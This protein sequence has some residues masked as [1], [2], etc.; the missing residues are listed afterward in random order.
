MD[1]ADLAFTP[2]TEM[3]SLIRRKALSPVEL[4]GIILDR[5]ERINPIL[6]AYCTITAEQARADARAAEAALM[7]GD[8]LGALHGLPISIK[9]L[10]YTRGVRTT[11]GS[12][13]FAG[14]VPT[15]DAPVVERVKAAG[16]IVIGKTNTPEFGWKG[17]TSND[18]FGATYNPWDRTRSAGGSSGGAAAALAAGLGPLALGTDGAGSIRIPAAFCGVVGLKAQL[19]RVPIYPPSTLETLSYTGPMARTVR[20]TALLLQVIAGH[21]ARDRLSL[22]DTGVDWQAACE[23]G[24]RGL[25]V[26]WSP[27]L[28]YAAVEPEVRAIAEA[29][30]RC[31]AGDLGC[32]LEEASPGFASPGDA[33]RLLFYTG[34]AVNMAG[35]D[36]ERRALLDPELARA[37]EEEV[38]GRSALDYALACGTRQAVWEACRPFFQHYDLLLTPALAVLPFAVGEEGPRVVAGR[39]V[40]RFDWT[41]FTYPFNLTGQPALVL[42]AGWSAGGLPVGL[43]IVG[44]LHDEVTVLR[45]GAA[46]EAAQP[47]AGRRPEG[48]PA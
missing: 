7:R 11:R 29:A 13:L 37:I 9:D 30:A 44:R 3:A 33:E 39:P 41:P 28:G 31:F 4:T 17:D 22:P 40:G 18:V 24:V 5:I 23:G 10:T 8:P 21:D 45:A 6:N 19:W 2:A 16:A 35:L 46:F 20:D 15:E 12:R 43:Q 27:D 32:D 38:E 25:R 1:Q 48:L 36:P 47:W 42:P 34:I 14:Y 26:A